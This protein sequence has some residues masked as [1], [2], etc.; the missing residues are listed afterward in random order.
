MTC[1]RRIHVFCGCYQQ[2]RGCRPRPSLGQ[3]LRRHDGY[4]SG[5]ETAG[6]RYY[7]ARRCS[8]SSTYRVAQAISTISTQLLLTPLN[9]SG[10]DRGIAGRPAN[11]VV[12]LV[13]METVTQPSVP[14][15][16]RSLTRRLRHD[17]AAHARHRG[18]EDR[19]RF[20]VPAAQ[21]S[22]SGCARPVACRSVGTRSVRCV[23]HVH[24][25]AGRRSADARPHPRSTA[26][27]DAAQY[28][29]AAAARCDPPR[30][31]R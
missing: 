25:G 17:D 11:A 21:R 13:L 15:F 18:G 29:R 4:R 20:P 5:G 24:R 28:D 23:A 22:G 31:R 8:L 9:S 10:R 1:A 7:A 2:R 26:A 19:A 6:R 16:D 30:D 12:L 27:A 14:R 3:A